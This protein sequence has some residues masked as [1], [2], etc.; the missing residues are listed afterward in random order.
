MHTKVNM[1]LVSLTLAARYIFEYVF[2]LLN[3]SYRIIESRIPSHIYGMQWLVH[4][5]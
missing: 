5:C 1:T 4:I 3:L 2:L